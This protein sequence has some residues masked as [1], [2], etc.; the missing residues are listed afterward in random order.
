MTRRIKRSK[1]YELTLVINDESFINPPREFQRNAILTKTINEFARELNHLD[2]QARTYVTGALEPGLSTDRTQSLLTDQQIMEDWQIPL[3]RAMAD[4]ICQSK[5]DILEIGFGRG[6]SSSMIQDYKVQSHTI[7]EC[8]PHVIDKFKH[9][10]LQQSGQNIYLITG[11][12]Q[13]TIDKLPLYDGIFF[14]T[15]PLN[16]EEYLKYV[17]GSVT[18]AEHFF[19]TASEHLRPGG[20]FTYFSNEIDSVS[21]PHQRALFENFTEIS[22][23]LVKLDL[24]KD[25]KD[26]WWTNSIVLIKAIK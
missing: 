5:G 1:E 25:V 2:R 7:I 11:L 18:F 13:D 3:M 16:K 22:T 4:A 8:N 12:W 21:R 24:P 20:K 10:K 14:H 23:S 9:W 17:H 19:R 26:T 15:Y 6:I